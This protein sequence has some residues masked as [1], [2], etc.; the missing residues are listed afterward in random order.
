MKL[1]ANLPHNYVS[2]LH[3]LTAE[4]LDASPLPVG[5][6]PV[7]AGPLTLLMCHFAIPPERIN[8]AA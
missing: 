7:A 4:P 1:R 5:I 8:H 2:R 6:T 3:E